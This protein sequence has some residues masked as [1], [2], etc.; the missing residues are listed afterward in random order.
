VLKANLA[1][2]RTPHG[3]HFSPPSISQFLTYKLIQQIQA[4]LITNNWHVS[5]MCAIDTTHLLHKAEI[6]A[7]G[8]PVWPHSPHWHKEQ[9]R[10]PAP[11]AGVLSTR[12]CE[13]SM[14]KHLIY[15]YAMLLSY[16]ESRSENTPATSRTM[17]TEPGNNPFNKSFLN[18]QNA[19]QRGLSRR[20]SW[21]LAPIAAIRTDDSQTS[22]RSTNQQC[23]IPRGLTKSDLFEA[24]PTPNRSA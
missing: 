20:K 6:R 19:S 12:S 18:L 14:S 8:Q 13:D 17:Y 3:H 9:K 2:D 5:T 22:Q 11:R 10:Q 4:Q 15:A 1:L 16:S 23:T 21:G 7:D 24:A